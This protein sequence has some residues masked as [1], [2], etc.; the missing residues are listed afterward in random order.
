MS[1]P[2][3]VAN[4]WLWI[5]ISL[6]LLLAAERLLN[7]ASLQP[8]RPMLSI[9]IFMGF[10]TVHGVRRYGW[11]HFIVFFHVTGYR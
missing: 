2:T 8:L 11:R 4:T 3:K 10:A 7:I 6:Y 5:F 1:I 9:A